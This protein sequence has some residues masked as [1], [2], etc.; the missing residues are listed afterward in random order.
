M[1]TIYH[2]AIPV[3]LADPSRQRIGAAQLFMGDN[4]SHV[5]TALVADTDAPEAGLRAGTV[6]GTALR[7]DGVT[8]ALEGTKGADVQEVTFPNGVTAQATPC[9]VTLPQAAFAV[10]GSLLISIK[11]V[12]GTTATTVLA[13]TGTVVRTETDAA[14][15]PGE[16]LPDLAELQ[17]AAA[18]ALSAASE[19]RSEAANVVAAVDGITIGSYNLLDMDHA[20][21]QN[22]YLTATQFVSSVNS[23]CIVFP[24][25]VGKTFTFSRKNAGSRLAVYFSTTDS[26]ETHAVSNGVAT[27]DY[28][29]VTYTCPSGYPYVYIW[30]YRSQSDSQGLDWCLEE[31]QIVEGA[32]VK[33]YQP[34]G[35]AISVDADH[36]ADAVN[37]DIAK[38][39]A[40]Y[41]TTVAPDAWTT[42]KMIFGV[43]FDTEAT[44]PACTRIADA[45]A[46]TAEDFDNI[47][48]WCEMKR[49]AVTISGGKKSIV[50]EGETGYS[51][52]GSAGNVMVE[53][54]AFYVCRERIGTTERWLIS[55]T[56]YGGFELHPWFIEPDGS[57]V[58]HRYYGAYKAQDSDSGIFSRSG[59]TP[60]QGQNQ[61][62][63]Y[64]VDKFAAAGFRRNSI[65]AWSALQYL[66]LIE[67]ATRSTQTVY[68]GSTY[69]PYFLPT[70]SYAT[71]ELIREITTVDGHSQLKLDRG[72]TY[73]GNSFLFYSAGMQ[74][75]IG[76]ASTGGTVRNILAITYD[77]SSV[78]MTVDGAT[79]S[80]VDGLAA[81]GIPS[82]TG[83]TD[84]LTVPS[85]YATGMDSHVASFRYRGIE[86]PWGSVWEILDGLKMKNGVYY[87]SNDPAAA[88]ADMDAL[89]YAA[90]MI[91]ATDHDDF[92]WI[93]RLGYDVNRRVY[94]LPDT[95]FTDAGTTVTIKTDSG[96]TVKT[97]V[98]L[99][100]QKYYG[101]AYYS[102]TST[103]DTLFFAVGG[104][105]DHHENAGLF[106]Y[107]GL[108]ATGYLYGERITC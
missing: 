4:N 92:N 21:I 52:T 66:F 33:P 101:D 83:K 103:T 80:L 106:C 51:V 5:F 60:N 102:T 39:V 74:V 20:V 99:R 27:E 64:L 54:P 90:P 79:I 87:V 18:D 1:S 12:D 82:T 86:D 75:Y 57:T 22:G 35:R 40:A 89:T 41:N 107:R 29:S 25:T 46:L 44:S 104:G 8:V 108:L 50:Y 34:F 49:C 59:A 65:Q 98:V 84:S 93:K 15:D 11:L 68:N 6:S 43:E 85:G 67:H 53:V 14:V 63:N 3:N 38:G 105:W 69:N 24:A 94:A 16:I 62:V 71:C 88:L 2:A 47:F 42:R 32:E 19:A 96:E 30:V 70:S 95:L 81:A 26:T 37:A 23:R 9:S 91:S 58:T 72:G 28:K 61:T 17:A 7:A 31:A 45:A 48:P 73:S 100:G 13:V 97:G 77:A 55:G 76:T 36:L 56:Q 78:Y 10:P